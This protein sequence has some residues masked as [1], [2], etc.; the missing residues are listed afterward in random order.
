[1]RVQNLRTCKKILFL[2]LR[3]IQEKTVSSLFFYYEEIMSKSKPIESFEAGLTSGTSQGELWSV[4]E[5]KTIFRDY[6]RFVCRLEIRRETESRPFAVRGRRMNPECKQFFRICVGFPTTRPSFVDARW[7]ELRQCNL[8][9]WIADKFPVTCILQVN[10]IIEKEPTC[11]ECSEVSE[12]IYK[13]LAILSW[14]CI[15]LKSNYKYL[16]LST[17]HCIFSW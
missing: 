15:V 2:T 17:V 9:R 5:R 10:W 14:I 1:M 16:I 6:F 7:I 3:R 12:F 4:G 8:L 11:L 13:S